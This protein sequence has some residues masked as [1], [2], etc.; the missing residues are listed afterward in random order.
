MSQT[1]TISCPS[2]YD[3]LNVASLQGW[4]LKLPLISA[5][6]SSHRSQHARTE[7]TEGFGWGAFSKAFAPGVLIA[8]SLCWELGLIRL[9]AWEAL[10]AGRAREAGMAMSGMKEALSA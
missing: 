5:M 3:S 10:T 9:P 6:T 2:S 1:W 8:A 4:A 7:N